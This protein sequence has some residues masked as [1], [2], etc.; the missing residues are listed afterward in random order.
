[1]K[2]LF[3]T[4]AILFISTFIYA[5]DEISN[6]AYNHELGINITSVIENIFRPTQYS[7]FP[8]EYFLTYKYH[9]KKIS[10]RTR[11]GGK[12]RSYDRENAISQNQSNRKGNNS[13]FNIAI[14]IEKR[15]EFK[16][17]WFYNYGIESIY[18]Y[19]YSLRTN[20]GTNG[21]NPEIH[22]K[23]TDMGFGVFLGF[24]YT[25]QPW[26]SIGSEATYQFLSSSSNYKYE[27]MDTSKNEDGF[28]KETNFNFIPTNGIFI[29][30]HF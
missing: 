12:K 20:V 4:L 11:I 3:L 7:Y 24:N 1:M 21:E 26:I 23:R 28:G 29:R 9:T 15:G 5:Q 10:L 2:N 22:D 30:I 6:K 8:D 17:K 25:I 14:G 19:N 18:H 13:E 27:Y 16:N